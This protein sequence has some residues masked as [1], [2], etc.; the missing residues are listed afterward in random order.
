MKLFQSALRLSV[1]FGS[2]F[3][4]FGGWMLLAHADKPVAVTQE[5]TAPLPTLEPLDAA[6]PSQLQPLQPLQTSPQFSRP[7]LRTRGS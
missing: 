1:L 7:M 5:P 6:A 3:G 4:F 2:L